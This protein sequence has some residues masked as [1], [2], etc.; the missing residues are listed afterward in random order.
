M[1]GNTITLSGRLTALTDM[2]TP[3]HTVCDLGCDHGFLSI[4]LVE[5]GISPRIVAMDVRKGPLSRAEAHIAQRGLEKYITLRLSDGLSAF[6]SGEADTLVCAGM[7]GRLMQRILSNAQ[8]KAGSFRELILQPQSDIA[9]FRAYLRE[10]GYRTVAENIVLEE[11]KFYPM[12]KVVPVGREISCE[13]PLFD[14]FGEKLL[15]ERH[16]VL[17]QYL[18]R[19]AGKLSILLEELRRTQD[20]PRAQARLREVGAELA[21]VQEALERF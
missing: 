5:N 20:S 19:S 9:A 12:M 14:L 10:K 21:S 16:P 6:E 8:G 7:G 2:V 1:M 11:G 13:D 3:G 4:F 18:V 17:K 15:T